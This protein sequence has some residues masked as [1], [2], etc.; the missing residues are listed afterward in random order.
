MVQWHL[1]FYTEDYTPN[2]R[3]FDSFYGYYSGCEDYFDH[4]YAA[5]WPDRVSIIRPHFMHCINAVYMLATDVARSMVCLSVSW[6]QGFVIAG[7][8]SSLF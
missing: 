6:T 8:R 3:G 7:Q 2:R 1:G 4:T 5:A